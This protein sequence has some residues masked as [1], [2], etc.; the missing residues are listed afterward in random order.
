MVT[1]SRPASRPATRP[2][3]DLAASKRERFVNTGEASRMLDGLISA[4]VLR[5]M[6]LNGEIKGAVRVRTRVLIP[7]YIVP[8]LVK[9]L[10]FDR[11]GVPR[12]HKPSST[13]DAPS[14]WASG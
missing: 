12:I 4:G 8:S 2:D 6:A 5:Q 7:R 11:V 9:E 10:E 14:R 1:T 3:R 13:Y